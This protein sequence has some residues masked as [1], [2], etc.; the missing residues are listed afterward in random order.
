MGVVCNL[1][2]KVLTNSPNSLLQVN[3]RDRVQSDNS[4]NVSTLAAEDDNIGSHTS[5]IAGVVVKTN[6]V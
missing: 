3:P 2:S 1:S 5:I 4:K 6:K